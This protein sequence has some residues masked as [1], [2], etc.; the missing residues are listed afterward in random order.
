MTHKGL[1]KNSITTKLI[2]F[3]MNSQKRILSTAVILACLSPVLAQN[4]IR[5]DS[6]PNTKEVENRN[7]M[8]NASADNQPRQVSIGLPSEMSATIYE[9]GTPVSWT[10]WPLLPYFYWASSPAYDHVGMTSLSENAI[11]N[12]SVNYTIDSWTRE[13]GNKFQGNVNYTTNI[14]GLQRFS[15]AASGPIKKGWSFSAGAY[16]NLDPGTNK[17]ADTHWQNDMKQFKFGL[18]KRFNQNKGKVSLFYKYNLTRNASDNNAPFIFVGDGS[19]K[20]Y[21]GFRMG[22]DGFLPAH[23]QIIYQDVVTGE[24]KSVQRNS[25]MSAL[26]NDVNL[27][28]DY[29]FTP[30]LHLSFLS[31]YHYANVHYIGLAV[32]GIGTADEHSGYTY[33]YDT[34]T[35]KDGD[36]F[37]GNYATRFFQNEI[38]HEK[39]WYN[40]LELKG[41]SKDRR[42]NWR[43][44]LNAWWMLPDVI[45]ST[46]LYAHTV[47]SDPLWLKSNGS[48]GS[49][50]NTGGEY[51]DT[52][53]LKTAFYASDDWQ[54]TD[55]LWLSAGLRL[56]YYKLGGRNMM[57]TDDT[58]AN[59]PEN[60][61]TPG[62]NMK[63]STITRIKEAWFNPAAQLNAR[64]TITQGFGVLAEG[65]YA[66]SASGSPNFSGPDA[67]NTDPIN[68]TFAR[69]GVFWNNSWIKLVSQISFIQ[70]TNYQRR[71]QFTNPNN[72]ADV[73]TLP[74]T[75]DI[76]T[77]G[78]TTDVVLTPFKGFNFHG[79]F[80]LQ[81]PKYKNFDLTATFSDGSSSS[82][83]FNDNYSP[84]VSKIIVELDPSYTFDKF[85]IWTS[86]RY[87]SKQYINRTNSLFFNG[88]WE[89]FA[90]VDYNMNKHVS[91]SVNMINLFNQK[92]ASGNISSAD[93]VEDGSPYQNYLMA[94]N[95]IRPFT[96]EFSAN[97]KF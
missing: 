11:T 72:A 50:F 18:T 22:K 74:T 95:Y 89:T 16:T 41:N 80:T 45:T 21:N 55:R 81:E 68:T 3:I 13:G 54:A 51:Y 88:R 52:H 63:N 17:M 1:P 94:G 36:L 46:G 57:T 76:Q 42:H 58:G 29:D 44:G 7:V 49:A 43:L 38:G 73:V 86:F 34:E 35:H 2:F 53:E 28:F 37:T 32:S 14:Y 15:V 31:K 59:Y 87:Q 4:E 71:T 10:W 19:V 67:P 97:I 62:W 26:S 96:V 56:E 20:E 30:N 8:L 65:V 61:R 78:W 12:G 33:A 9:D 6:V 83:N 25:G 75:Y 27:K 77:V 23:S 69:G 48:Q 79:L 85:R 24:M 92:G 60:S 47:E 70:K 91:L 64:Y 93:L 82:Y 5:K 39:A 84:G 90:G 40:T 66:S